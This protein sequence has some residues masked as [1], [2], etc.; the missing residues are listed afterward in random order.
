MIGAFVT[1]GLLVGGGYLMSLP[2]YKKFIE[3]GGNC[4]GAIADNDSLPDDENLKNILY[5]VCG[6]LGT[7]AIVALVL[8]AIWFL[9]CLL[10]INMASLLIHGARHRRPALLKPWLVWTVVSLILQVIVI[11]ANFVVLAL[12]SA[13]CHIIG[14]IIEG[15]IFIGIVSFWYKRYLVL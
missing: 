13:I 5:A 9:I 11:I 8:V 14:L 7:T 1:L 4:T 6:N 12:P 2:D 3:N 10:H 15:Y